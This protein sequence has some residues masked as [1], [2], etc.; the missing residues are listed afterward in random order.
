MSKPTA[1]EKL[2]IRDD[3]IDILL[4]EVERLTAELEQVK[5]EYAAADDGQRSQWQINHQL[6]S[7]LEQVKSERDQALKWKYPT[8]EQ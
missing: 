7:E 8:V 1:A 4:A 5:C 3:H 6:H 2:Q